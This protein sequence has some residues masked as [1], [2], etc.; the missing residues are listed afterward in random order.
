MHS[1]QQRR[2]DLPASLMCIRH[3]FRFCMSH[4]SRRLS[5]LRLL[6][7]HPNTCA[8]QILDKPSV[9][10]I[11]SLIFRSIG[12]CAPCNTRRER[13]VEHVGLNYRSTC[14]R[15]QPCI[16]RRYNGRCRDCT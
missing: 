2:P 14:C 6:C 10:D 11:E 12:P 5:E 4:F 7:E 1:W 16:W 13:I 3:R 15:G 9:R 8:R